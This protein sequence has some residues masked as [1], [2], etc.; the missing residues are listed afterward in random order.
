MLFRRLVLDSFKPLKRGSLEVMLP[1]GENEIF[2]G[3]YKGLQ[4]QISVKDNRFFRRCVLFGPIGFAE[5]YMAGEWTTPDLTKVIAWFIL[6][7]E[8]A[9]GLKTRAGR[10]SGILNILNTYN[11]FL[12]LGRPNSLG[13]SREN[14]REHYDLSN[15]FFRL[16]LDPTMTYSSAYFDPPDLPLEAAQRKKYDMLCRKL[17]LHPSDEVLEIGSGWGGFSMHAAKTHG[18]RVTTITISEQQ[19][20]EASQRIQAAGLQDRIELLLCDYRTLRGR[21]DKIASIEMLE[22]VGDKF[23]DGFFAK[24]DELLKPEGLLGLQAIL[25]P[26][27]QYPILRDG[28]D[29]IQKHIFPGSLLMSNG[30]IAEALQRT[31]DFNLLAYEDMAPFYARTLKIWRENFE[32]V[33]DEVRA[34][35]FDDAFIRKW[36]YYLCYCEAAF[37]TRHITVAQAVYARPNNLSLHSPAYDLLP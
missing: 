26:D 1:G 20:A 4:A 5:S 6:N 10:S 17:Q 37:G 7:A 18:C 14:I 34:Q 13:K 23:V 3:L 33:L 9:G 22:A 30:R 12:H 15:D 36:R 21:F 28:V 11:R 29:F 16:W 32:A 31:G 19:F 8:D 35:G 2:G 24:C 27:R 25:C